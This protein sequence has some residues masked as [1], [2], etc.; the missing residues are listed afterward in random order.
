AARHDLAGLDGA[1]VALSARDGGSGGAAGAAYG[2]DP[3]ARP[4]GG[5]GALRRARAAVSP[6]LARGRRAWSARHGPA[7]PSG[8][9][10]WL[11]GARG[12]AGGRSALGGA[13][14]RGRGLLARGG[15]GGRWGLTPG[16]SPSA[17]PIVCRIVTFHALLSSEAHA[18]SSLDAGVANERAPASSEGRE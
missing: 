12:A 7:T 15:R 14:P 17:S 3:G 8:P 2:G 6:P 11:R 4:G 13:E 9:G 1:R 5:W 16:G 10:L 18:H